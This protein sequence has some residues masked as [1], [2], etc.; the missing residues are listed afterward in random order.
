MNVID[1][2]KRGA[3][4]IPVSTDYVSLVVPISV[5]SSNA[6]FKVLLDTGSTLFA[7][8]ASNCYTCD[9]DAPNKPLNINTVTPVSSLILLH[10]TYNLFY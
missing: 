8:P 9:T 6:P 2:R 1:G 4:D 7:I 3:S 5:G 10:L